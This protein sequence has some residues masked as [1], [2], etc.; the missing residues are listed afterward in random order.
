MYNAKEMYKA[1]QVKDFFIRKGVSPLKLQKLLFYAQ[2][3]YFAKYE[4]K[5]FSEDIEAWVLGPVVPSVWQSLRFIRRG[6][7]IPQRKIS[8]DS[9]LDEKTTEHLEEIWRVYGKYSGVQLVDITHAENLWLNARA[10]LPD[11]INCNNIIHIDRN[12]FEDFHLDMFGK[13]PHTRINMPGYGK[14]T[15]IVGEEIF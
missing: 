1:A 15:G 2:V 4:E 10:G 14:I 5:L 3:W 13:I 7:I 9:I 8:G 11:H 6:D 12:I